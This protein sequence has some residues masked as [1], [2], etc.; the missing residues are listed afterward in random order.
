MERT[1][2]NPKLLPA[3]VLT[4]ALTGGYFMSTAQAER[5]P[6]MHKAL[7]TLH[8]AEQQLSKATHDKG[9]H[10]AKALELVRAAIAEV[11]Q[12][13]AYDNQNKEQPKSKP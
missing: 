4:L 2:F 3:A 9:G 5:Q 6:H 13:I 11:K 8:T 10:R 7:K 1:A 12:G